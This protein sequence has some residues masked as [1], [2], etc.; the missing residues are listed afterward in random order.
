[1]AENQTQDAR[2][3]AL[4]IV[5]PDEQRAEA[6]IAAYENLPDANKKIAAEQNLVQGIQERIREIDEQ[7]GKQVDEILHAPK[8]KALEAVWNGLR[9][10]ITKTET[11]TR[12]KLK[13]LVLSKDELGN[14]L[15]RAVDHDQSALFRKIYEEEYGTFG[16]HPFSM[17]VGSYEF[18]ENPEDVETLR[19]LS[20]VAA[21]SHAPFV[22]AASPRLFELGEDYAGLSKPRDLAKIFE[23]PDELRMKW[24]EFRGS[25][26]SRYVTLALPRVLIRKPYHSKTNPVEGFVYDEVVVDDEHPVTDDKIH[27]PAIRHGNYLWGS[28]AW[29]LA[30]RITKAFAMYSWCGAIRGVE[31]GGLVQGL[32][33]HTFTTDEGEASMKGPTEVT[34]T[35]RRERE[36]DQLGFVALCHRKGSAEAAFFG[37][38]TAQKPKMYDLPEAN[39]NAELS[40]RLPYLLAA[41]RFAHYLKVIVREKVGGFES[42]ESVSRYLNRWIGAYVLGRDDAGQELKAQYPLREARVDVTEIPGRPGA[43]NAVVFLR[44]H[45]QLEELT[46]SLRLVAELPPPA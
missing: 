46:T 22:A 35:D 26:D 18:G 21:A 3:Q 36:L 15:E 14:D 1:M 19:K 16:G 27:L 28:A 32:P 42:P 2:T 11:S 20:G 17:L 39:A 37:G 43:Y 25:E 5:A 8:F 33:V 9:Y 7:L 6:L 41:S 40:A 13:L 12:L 45:F 24:K 31:G 38:Q 23:I 44:P 29:V 30:E 4:A 34:I 10:L